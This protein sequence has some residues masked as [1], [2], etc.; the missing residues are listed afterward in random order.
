MRL[1]IVLAA[2]CISSAQSVV[3]EY[4]DAGV[5]G[6]NTQEKLLTSSNVVSGKFGLRCQV[7]PDSSAIYAQPL[8][9]PKLTVAGAV[10]DVGFTVTMGNTAAAFDAHTCAI[11]W[12]TSLGA[13]WPDPMF[14]VANLYHSAIG[15]LSTPLID[16]ANGWL[17][18][19]VAV[20]STPTYMLK[21]LSLTT[22]MV[23]ASTAVSG[24]FPGTGSK[25]FAG[26]T[27]TGGNLQFT[28]R[29]HDQREGLVLNKGNVIVA[30]AQAGLLN[31]P[32]HGWLKA[33]D[34]ATLTSQG[35]LCSTPSG[36]GGG[37]WGGAPSQDARGD[38]FFVTADGDYNGTVN[39]GD[40]LLKVSPSLAIADWFT[41][42]NQAT[43]HTRDEDPS[44][45]R[46]ILIPGTSYLASVP[47]DFT[48]RLIDS[49]NMQ[50]MQGGAGQNIRQTFAISSGSVSD[51]TGGYSEV[52]M[53]NA[54]YVS[55]A[56]GAIY[57]CAWNPG[58]GLFTKPCTASA[59]A[60]SFPG[61]I[62]SGSCNGTSN[63][64]L[65]AVTVSADAIVN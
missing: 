55:T 63:C 21:K 20:G 35:T 18:A 49:T 12:S 42:Y 9:V 4:Y 40:T 59:A 52:F 58:T 38:L 7:K 13:P 44:S 22:G 50:H 62:L 36:N 14:F 26:D 53:N 32:W 24:S 16:R 15:D 31:V 51:V 17:F 1:F 61:A 41:P 8:Y 6:T 43:L 29:W 19:L 10:H 57:R 3:S 34:E 37:F 25:A 64:I 2:T 5:T 28:S 45:N 54:L 46:L 27:V 30:F 33:Y 60:F 11:L 56:H 48:L 39:F 65:W 47:K 23:L